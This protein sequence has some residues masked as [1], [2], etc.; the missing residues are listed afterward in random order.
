MKTVPLRSQSDELKRNSDL[1]GAVCFE[2]IALLLVTSEM[3]VGLR[4]Q[5][6][7]SLVSL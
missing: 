1:I 7:A 3:E 5:D 4:L 2:V 6:I